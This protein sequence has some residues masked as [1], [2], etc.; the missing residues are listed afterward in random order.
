MFTR[1]PQRFI[2][3]QRELEILRACREGVEG[4]LVLLTGRRR[5]GKTYLLDR[6]LSGY[7][8]VKASY[9][10]IFYQ[11]TRQT[12]AA[13]LERFASVVSGVVGALP[14]GYRFAR[15]SD[16]LD[17]L[18]EKARERLI[19]VF[20]EFPYLCEST[21]GLASIVQHW[22]DRVGR[23]SQ[24]MLVL[25]G[26]SQTF[27]SE[28][29]ASSAPLHQRF[30]AKITLG[31]L[32]Y[33]EAAAF[34]PRLAPADLVRVYGIL[35]G[36]PL[37]LEQWNEKRSVREN[38]IEL[39][40]NPA[41]MLVDSAQLVLDAALP[42]SNAAYRAVQAVALGNTQR[43]AI[44]QNA[45]VTN[46][47]V[48]MRLEEVGLLSRRKPIT[49]PD[50]RRAIFVLSDPYFRFYFRF[51]ARERGA[52]DRGHGELLVDEH[53]LPELDGHLGFIFEEIA[54]GYAHRLIARRELRGTDVGSWWS[55]D[56]NHEIDIVGTL[57]D[58]PSFIGSVKW[59]VRPID[60]S[61]LK[62]LEEHARALGVDE[63]IPWLLVGRGGVDMKIL[64]EPHLRGVSIEDIYST[65]PVTY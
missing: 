14:P 37:Y 21:K 50:S 4:R 17:F 16:A 43:N 1:Q 30:T 36:T 33:R 49:E 29:D 53:I 25:C 65:S 27:M 42:D 62:N 61:V 35:G 28:L 38:L 44:L 45:K 24:I 34:T 40:G 13:E 7:G 48:L 12:E 59:R 2:G 39:F 15:W 18:T 58:R 3:R 64:S 56:G 54:R 19:V 6:F 23:R 51:I 32:D 11:A 60:R 47:R 22:W 5:I 57:R 63:S 8:E 52:I 31:P 20:D 10:S 26:S 55:R 46:E 9:A 41:S